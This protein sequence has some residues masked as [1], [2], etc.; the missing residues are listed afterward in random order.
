[1]YFKTH[2][3]IRCQALFDG[4]PG[5]LPKIIGIVVQMLN[6][7]NRFIISDPSN[8]VAG[9]VLREGELL[10]NFLISKIIQLKQKSTMYGSMIKNDNGSKFW[11]PATN[12]VTANYRCYLGNQK[13]QY[14]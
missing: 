9:S 13:L 11:S 12:L 1:M 4:V 14:S 7:S 6:L 10:N 2:Q 5:Q 8:G 3:S